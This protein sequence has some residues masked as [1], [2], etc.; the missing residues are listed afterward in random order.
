MS[1]ISRRWLRVN[2]PAPGTRRGGV[3]TP[4]IVLTLTVSVAGVI[5]AS[6]TAPLILAHRT[7]RIHQEDRLADYQR[8]DQVA[9]AV[10]AATV[11]AQ[12]ATVAAENQAVV[13]GRKLDDL[14]VQ[15]A[16]IHTLVNSTLTA[17]R[18]EELDQTEAVIVALQRVIRLTTERSIPP[19]PDDLR[20]LD[21]ARQRRDNLETVLA[22][23]LMQF[24]RSRDE[25]QQSAAGRHMLDTDGPV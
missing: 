11:A 8:Q 2:R 16:R 3:L 20:M 15:T 25:A 7:E 1:L 5:F 21:R 18:Q 23:R 22:D 9:R 4:A 24:R 13:T 6:I 12:A 19:D 10:Q 17:A 14:T